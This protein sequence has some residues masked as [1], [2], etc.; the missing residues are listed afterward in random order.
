MW[1]KRSAIYRLFQF[2]CNGHHLRSE[3]SKHK[4]QES[5]G[6][7]W[8]T[9]RGKNVC[10]LCEDHKECPA[11]IL[12]ECCANK[13]ARDRFYKAV[14]EHAGEEVERQMRKEH[15]ATANWGRVNGWL[16]GGGGEGSDEDFDQVLYHLV[17]FVY[18]TLELRLSALS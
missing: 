1:G 7:V 6:A 2:R 15:K 18:E 12:F 3:T 17:T 14:K 10:V 4:V 9:K 11:R 16:D 5:K 8:R 13:A